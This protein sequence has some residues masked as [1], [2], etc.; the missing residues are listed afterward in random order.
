MGTYPASG[1]NTISAVRV[2]GESPGNSV[3]S[4]A[5]ST[6]STSS[7]SVLFSAAPTASALSCPASNNQIY[8][9]AA[10]GAQFVIE[11]GIDHSGGDM[12]S[13]SV[14]SFEGC[15]A[16]CATATSC[17]DVSLS[18]SACYLKRTLGTAVTNGGIL[19]ARF[20][21][22]ASTSSSSASS[23][24]A[25]SSSSALFSTASFASSSSSTMAASSL[26]PTSS[27]SVASS[28]SSSSSLPSIS[29]S[30]S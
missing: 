11:C 18:G 27:T 1:S 16:A 24:P 25:S 10:T 6:S 26:V 12:S 29:S 2:S 7:S 14:K 5:P 20:I 28:S 4:T 30:S 8:T 9:Y 21:G 17:V 13:T 22:Y 15:I 19:G 23:S 3:S